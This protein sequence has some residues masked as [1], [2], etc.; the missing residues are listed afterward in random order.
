MWHVLLDDLARTSAPAWLLVAVA[1]LGLLS[2]SHAATLAARAQ[3][4]ATLLGGEPP[5]AV[6]GRRPAWFEVVRAMSWAAHRGRCAGCGVGSGTHHVAFEV[7]MGATFAALAWSTGVGW[8]LPA[9]LYLTWLTLTLGWI[10]IAV[11]RLPDQ[12]VVPGFFL[13]GAL[14]ALAAPSSVGHAALGALALSG[15]YFALLLIHPPAV[16]FGDVKLAVIVGA[17]LGSVSW[18]A[19][20]V[21]HLAAVAVGAIMSAVVLASARGKRTIA[22]GPAMLAGA[23]VGLVAGDQVWDWYLGLF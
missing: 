8:H 14:L 23:W 10:D 13:A 12:I 6:C 4:G 16:G 11:H 21:G 17:Y 15:M 1:L 7:V 22:F 20:A 9:L 19:L 2:G 18:G 5:C 3:V